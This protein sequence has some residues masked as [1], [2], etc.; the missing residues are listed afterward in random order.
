MG[1]GT[2]AAA[3]VVILAAKEL[4]VM[5]GLAE[6]EIKVSAALRAFQP[7]SKFIGFIADGWCLTAGS[8]FQSLYLI[9]S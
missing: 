8:G 1:G 4:D 2:L 7:P 3:R 9:A 6:M 5:V